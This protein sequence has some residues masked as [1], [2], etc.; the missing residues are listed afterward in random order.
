MFPGFN[1]L[2]VNKDVDLGM[3]TFVATMGKEWFPGT[4]PAN[5]LGCKICELVR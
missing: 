5:V 2:V 1:E 4:F 3:K